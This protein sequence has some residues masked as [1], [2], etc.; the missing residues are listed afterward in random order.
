MGEF[1]FKRW[2]IFTP[3]TASDI[4]DILVSELGADPSAREVFVAYLS[5]EKPLPNWGREWRFQGVLGFGGKLY[6]ERGLV[7]VSCYAEDET[8][9]RRDLMLGVNAKLAALVE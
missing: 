4:Y 2:Q 9:A 5:Q 8:P 3:Q 6:A 7:R 1:Q